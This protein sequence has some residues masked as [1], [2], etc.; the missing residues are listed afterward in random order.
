MTPATF[1]PITALVLLVSTL[2]AIQNL[3]RYVKA[4]DWN[5]TGGILLAWASG[6]LV[7]T[8]GAQSEV[9]DKLVLITGAPALGLLGWASL[10][11]LGISVG[12]GGTVVADARN[13]RDASTSAAKPPLVKSQG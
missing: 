1:G 8:L 7:V 4:G 10:V 6:I 11:M 13:A 3:I 5:G 2:Y 9:T 12:S